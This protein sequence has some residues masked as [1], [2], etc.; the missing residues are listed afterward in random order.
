MR[1]PRFRPTRAS[2]AL[3]ALVTAAAET[4]RPGVRN[5]S[6]W[7]RLRHRD[8]RRLHDWELRRELRIISWYLATADAQRDWQRAWFEER[9]QQIDEELRL[10]A[11]SREGVAT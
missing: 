11:R 1:S 9:L 5:E 6:E 2:A 8:L 3:D 10:R 4:L 7:L